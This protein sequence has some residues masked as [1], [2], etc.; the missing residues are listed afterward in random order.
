MNDQMPRCLDFRCEQ[1]EELLR[2]EVKALIGQ[3]TFGKVYAAIEARSGTLTA[4][5]AISKD[6][7]LTS[8]C[9]ESTLLEKKILL[10]SEH[11]FLINM[12]HVF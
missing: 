7:V 2:Y 8:G 10:A 1:S 5:K 4:I 3:G 11:P 12:S 6:Q 9:L